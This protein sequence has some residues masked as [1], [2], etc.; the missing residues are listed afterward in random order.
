MATASIS[1]LTLGN[2][3]MFFLDKVA[4]TPGAST[5]GNDPVTLGNITAAEIAPDVSY[6]EH[7]KSVKGNRRKDKTVAITKSINIPFTFDE[8]STSNLKRF[9][10]G[11]DNTAA[12]RAIMLGDNELE[13]R[14]VLNFQTNIGTN[15]IYV[16]PKCMLR[17]DGGLAFTSED[18]MNGNFILEVLYHDTFTCIIGSPNATAAPY[19]YLA[20]GRTSI[21]SPFTV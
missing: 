4:S 2:C 5:A 18:W 6:V 19:G 12:T 14:A 1:D 16:I 7:F 11:H 8:C 9:F 15:F 20:F 3:E 21:G 10:L 13:G 17:P